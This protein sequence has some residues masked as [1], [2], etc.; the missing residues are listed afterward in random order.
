M[1]SIVY[2]YKNAIYINLTNRCPCACSYCIKNK[3]GWRFRGGHTLKLQREPEAEEVLNEVKKI[4]SRPSDNGFQEIV[5]CGYG[6]PF[7][8]YDVMRA[9]AK[10]LKNAGW[11]I[12]VNTTGLAEAS[13][14][15]NKG[16]GRSLDE[17]LDGLRGLVDAF[18][19]S[20]NA[21]DAD[22]Y[23]RVNRPLRNLFPPD[24]R[25]AF[26]SVIDFASAAKKKGFDV[27]LTAV[28]LPG[29]DVNA[30]SA[31]ASEIGVK[32]RPREYLDE[33]EDR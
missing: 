32:F 11:R 1:S 5:F 23:V 28:C 26:Y 31:L 16:A 24:G 27:T 22:G 4:A 17:L 15:M 29:L 2:T 21:S 14:G 19:V 3:W 10:E 33:Y 8:R 25:S 30:V 6:E 7:M 12:R 20:M 13:D 18:S 9:V